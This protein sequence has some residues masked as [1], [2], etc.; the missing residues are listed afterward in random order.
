MSLENKVGFYIGQKYIYITGRSQIP[1]SYCAVCNH[2]NIFEEEIL[3][4]VT[5]LI[6]V[7]VFIKWL[8]TIFVALLV[9]HMFV[10]I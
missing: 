5:S 1:N 7:T 2:E 4:S 9:K 3:K 6:N 10:C 8:E